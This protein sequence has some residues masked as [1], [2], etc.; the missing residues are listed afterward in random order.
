[1][2]DASL[3]AAEGL[4]PLAGIDSA[5]SLDLE[6]TCGNIVCLLGPGGGGKSTWLRALAGVTPPAIGRL[7]LLGNDV[8]PYDTPAWRQLRC[9]AAFIPSG[10]PLLSVVDAL[11]NITLPALYHRI[12]SP[13]TIR[14]RAE[15][16]LDF[17]GYN[18]S[19]QALPAHL[20]Q[21]ERLL[22]AIGRCL[23]LSPRLLYLDEPFH[24]TDDACRRREA[25]IYQQLARERGM[26]VLVATHNLGFAKRY[27]T[28][29]VFVYSQGVWKFDSWQA[30][31]EAPLIETRAFLNA[32]A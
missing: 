9:Q 19:M 26:A 24:M 18:G 17:L 11:N 15:E 1:M 6:V 8:P 27:A 29:I 7:R 13:E 12:A 16:T 32:A 23:M 20:S 31:T 30:F 28:D 21:H 2:N 10:A 4:R 14:L 3:I 22:I 25:K 5:C